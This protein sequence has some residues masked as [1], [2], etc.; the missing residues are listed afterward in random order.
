MD[1]IDSLIKENSKPKE[2]HVGIYSMTCTIDY[3]YIKKQINN[4][5]KEL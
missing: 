5:F 2:Y 3:K 1:K 4:A